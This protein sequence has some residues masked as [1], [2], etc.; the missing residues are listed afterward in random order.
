M[1]TASASVDQN[2]CIKPSLFS[3]LH[4]LL[5][6]VFSALPA[7]MEHP[8]ILQYTKIPQNFPVASHLT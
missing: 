8:I 2:A 6:Q 1:V 3:A 4:L 5:F 7:K